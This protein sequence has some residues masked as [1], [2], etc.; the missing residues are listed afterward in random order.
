MKKSRKIN[1]R[2]GTLNGG[3]DGCDIACMAA[4]VRAH[5]RWGR[6]RV[7]RDLALSTH[8]GLCC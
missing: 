7:G 3:N 6:P 1:G 8:L 5:E 2:N 4:G